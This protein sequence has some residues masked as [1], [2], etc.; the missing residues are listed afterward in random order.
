VSRRRYRLLLKAK[1]LNGSAHGS[2][3]CHCMA[4]SLTHSFLNWRLI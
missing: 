2:G 4:L 1:A 3:A